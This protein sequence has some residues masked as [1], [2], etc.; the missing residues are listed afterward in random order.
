MTKIKV[1]DLD[2]FYNFYVHDFQLKSFSVP[3]WHLKLLFFEIQN[4]NR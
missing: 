4:S 2:E 1:L 3:K